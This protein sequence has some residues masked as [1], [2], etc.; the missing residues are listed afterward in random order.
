MLS[1][2]HVL[3]LSLGTMM[4]IFQCCPQ[5]GY[6]LVDREKTQK[7]INMLSARSLGIEHI[8]AER[9]QKNTGANSSS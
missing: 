4:N 2:Y 6:S 5:G 9:E 7:L 3:R 1:I 8:K